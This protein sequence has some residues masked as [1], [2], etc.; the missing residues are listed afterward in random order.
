MRFIDDAIDVDVHIGAEGDVQPLAFSWHGQRYP[1]VGIGRT[2]TQNDDRYF[3]VMTPG[4]RIFELRWHVPDNRWFIARAP[5]GR[6]V[7]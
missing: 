2:Y 6:R 4:D 3:L 5:E 1:I 7:A